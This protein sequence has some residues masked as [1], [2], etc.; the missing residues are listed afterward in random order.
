TRPPTC[1][2]STPRSCRCS[3]R[4]RRGP[5][6]PPHRGGGRPGASGGGP[7]GGRPFVL[8][9]RPRTPAAAPVAG[10]RPRDNH[11]VTVVR[12]AV[13]SS[14]GLTRCRPHLGG[15]CA[16]GHARLCHGHPVPPAAPNGTVADAGPERAV[17]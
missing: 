5:S 4:T 11:R 14:P 8:L 12:E 16:S 7:S 17:P 13:V 10:A 9:I 3:S 2:H 6:A 1:C 15:S